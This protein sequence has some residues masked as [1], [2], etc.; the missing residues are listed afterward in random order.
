M[1]G[2]GGAKGGLRGAE[3]TEGG[4]QQI[5]RSCGAG[6]RSGYQWGRADRLGATAAMADASR[7]LFTARCRLQHHGMVRLEVAMQCSHQDREHDL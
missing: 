7:A 1:L 6:V 3:E 5:G 2:A 4:S